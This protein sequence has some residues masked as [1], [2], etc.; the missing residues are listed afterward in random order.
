MTGLLL[1]RMLARCR[2]SPKHPCNTVGGSEGPK[3]SAEVVWFPELHAS[4]LA[5]CYV[6]PNNHSRTLCVAFNYKKHFS[7]CQLSPDWGSADMAWR[8]QYILC[9]VGMEQGIQ[10]AVVDY[11][12]LK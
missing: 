11:V 3:S 7:N 10:P 9:A 6:W 8:H 1:Q 5:S 12:K 2:E 4:A